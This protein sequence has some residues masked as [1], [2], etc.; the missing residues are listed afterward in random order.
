MKQLINASKQPSKLTIFD[1]EHIIID[2]VT[3]KATRYYSSKLLDMNKELT[4]IEYDKYKQ[5]AANRIAELIINS[6]GCS[7]YIS[8]RENAQ[9]LTY[10]IS[11]MTDEDKLK[12]IN[13][14]DN[15]TVEVNRKQ[16]LIDTI[17]KFTIIDHL[18]YLYTLAIT[19]FNIKINKFLRWVKRII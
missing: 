19:D 10:S 7:T 16:E 1:E 4:D 12:L 11:I 2:K 14:I 17:L 18:T 15:L 9:Y 3:L 13:K 6:L 8:N 5:Q